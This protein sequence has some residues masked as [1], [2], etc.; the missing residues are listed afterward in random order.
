MRLLL[1]L[2]SLAAAQPAL[3]ARLEAMQASI[4]ALT[5]TVS[6]QATELAALKAERSVEKRAPSSTSTNPAHRRL[7]RHVV[8]PGSRRGRRGEGDESG[9]EHHGRARRAKLWR[10]GRVG[11]CAVPAVRVDVPLQSALAS[12]SENEGGRFPAL[13]VLYFKPD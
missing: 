5:R 7:G 10:R 9:H 6:A 3:D 1:A 12:Q 13:P 11:R 2:S 8:G 4:D